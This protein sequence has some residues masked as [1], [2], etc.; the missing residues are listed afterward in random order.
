M[1]VNV[2]GMPSLSSTARV[3][4]PLS[5]TFTLKVLALSLVTPGTLPSSVTV[6]VNVFSR[7]LS[8]PNTFS[9]VYSMSPKLTLPASSFVVCMFFGIGA[10]SEPLIV[11]VYLPAISGALSPDFT[12][13]FL[14][15][16]IGLL[17]FEEAPYWLEKP[18]RSVPAGYSTRA[19]RVPLPSSV[20]ISLMLNSPFSTVTPLVGSGSSSVTVAS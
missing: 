8:V 14:A 1:L 6:Y 18:R 2:K 7:T 19:L 12:S 11:N 4:S 5:L 10:P 20:T 9:M 13:S 17:S 16:M 15:P 3:P